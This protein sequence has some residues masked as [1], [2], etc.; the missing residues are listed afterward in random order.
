VGQARSEVGEAFGAKQELAYH[1][2]RPT[3][4]HQVEGVGRSATI[5]IRAL[6]CHAH[7]FITV[8]PDSHLL[9]CSAKINS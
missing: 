7:D 2:K 8:S 9:D 5:V 3:F 1:Q 6:D 4:T